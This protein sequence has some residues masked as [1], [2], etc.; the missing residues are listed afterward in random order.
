MLAK[1]VRLKG[2]PNNF[3]VDIYLFVNSQENL[4]QKTKLNY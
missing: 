1:S 4:F 3:D 2:N